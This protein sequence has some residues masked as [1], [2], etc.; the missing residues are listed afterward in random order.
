MARTELSIRA[1]TRGALLPWAA[2][3]FPINSN[4]V[5]VGEEI[6]VERGELNQA[7]VKKK[8]SELL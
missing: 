5:N 4:F 6:Y 2:N 7:L 1:D 8:M 3:S